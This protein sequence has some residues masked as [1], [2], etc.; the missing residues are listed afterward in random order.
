MFVY[1]LTRFNVTNALLA[2]MKKN[3]YLY[4]RKTSH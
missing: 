3:L 1:G 4:Q 2:E